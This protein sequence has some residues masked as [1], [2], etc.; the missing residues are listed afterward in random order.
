VRVEDHEYETDFWEWVDK[1]RIDEDEREED[2]PVEGFVWDGRGPP[3]PG[4]T[5]AQQKRRHVQEVL[6]DALYP[7]LS[8]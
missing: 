7:A 6:F 8:P 5:E 4:E 3:L 2:G 1:G